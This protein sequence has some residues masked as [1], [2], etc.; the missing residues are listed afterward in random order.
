ML[1]GVE[2]LL[3]RMKTNPDEFVEGGYSKWSRVLDS[4]WSILNEDEKTAL[5]EGLI[6]AKRECFNGEVLRVLTGN[7]TEHNITGS[8]YAANLSAAI[9]NTASVMTNSITNAFNTEPKKMI[10]SS[11]MAK[12]A[13]EILEKE[14]DKSYA[15]EHRRIGGSK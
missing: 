1:T 3:E 8:L 15:Q 7:A 6:A 10:V 4:A 9:G 2:I 13:R 5:Q 12:Q 14:F 11:S